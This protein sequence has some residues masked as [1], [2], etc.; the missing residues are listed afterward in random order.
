LPT[1][2]R[3]TGPILDH[4]LH[5]GALGNLARHQTKGD[6]ANSSGREWQEDADRLHGILRLSLHWGRR[7][8]SSC[9]KHCQGRET[10]TRQREGT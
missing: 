1:Q 9:S 6:V 7:E 10:Q 8:K 2:C 5:A 4:E 3:R